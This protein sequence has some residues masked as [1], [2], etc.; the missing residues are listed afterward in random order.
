MSDRKIRGK[1]VSD[2]QVQAWSDE[3]EAGYD[4]PKLRRR[5]R[6]AAGDGP[7]EVVAVRLDATTLRALKKRAAA[8]GLGNQ[9]DA[10]RAAVRSWTHVA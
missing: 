4:V 10:L 5:G 3:A 6:P 9:S 7:G 8:E 1:A 2:E